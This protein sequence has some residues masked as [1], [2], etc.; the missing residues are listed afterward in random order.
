MAR[1]Y[2]FYYK[3]I[4]SARFQWN[5]MLNALT[6]TLGVSQFINRKTTQILRESLKEKKIK[7]CTQNENIFK[8]K[9]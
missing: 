1:F 6:P 3:Q 8:D 4:L 9:I 2:N 7:N 5:V